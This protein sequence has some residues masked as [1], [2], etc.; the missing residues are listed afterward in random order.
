MD[1]SSPAAYIFLSQQLPSVFSLSHHKISHPK[2][3]AFSV[4]FVLTYLLPMPFTYT[5]V[6]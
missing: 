4:Q 6:F 2:A 5:F 3:S 1:T